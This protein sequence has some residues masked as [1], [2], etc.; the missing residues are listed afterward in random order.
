MK[1]ARVAT[2]LLSLSLLSLALGLHGSYALGAGAVI[3]NQG[4][5][6]TSSSQVI[7]LWSGTCNSSSYLR[8]DGACG[9][10]AGSGT[11]TNTGGNL[12]SNS[13]V[14]GAGTADTKVIAGLTT[15]GVSAITHGVAG[16]SVGKAI[17]AN[18]TSGTI[19]LQPVTGALGSVTLSMPAITDT[20]VT[21]TAT[22]TLTNK[23]LTSPTLTTPALGTP[24]ALVLTNATGLPLAAM[25]NL[26]TTTTVLHGNAAGNPSFGA[27]SLSADVTGNLPVTNLNSGTSASS[28]TYWRGDGT[29]AT[30]TGSGTVNS[31]TQYQLAYYATS[32]A[33][34]STLGSLGSSGQV[35]TSNGAGAAP[36]WQASAAGGITVQTITS[37][38]TISNSNR[39]VLCDAT[40]GA[41][42]VNLGAAATY[43][44][45][46][47]KKID[48]SANACTVDPNSSETIDGGSTA[49]ISVQYAS[50]SLATDGSNWFIY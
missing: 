1:T 30:P 37:T 12:T 19:T 14:L 27:V 23:T 34:V 35:L 32:A 49:V 29:W 24:S 43:Q 17:F 33:A 48:S 41:V 9:S 39:V 36:T 28:S 40:S 38:S 25:A 21:L 13:L 31:G 16:T 7:S 15:D 45:I 44:N 18:A 42:T 2:A 8:G 22:Q 10:P 47:V 4:G 50:I 20:L 46:T 6:A 26:G 3:T 11:V 5:G